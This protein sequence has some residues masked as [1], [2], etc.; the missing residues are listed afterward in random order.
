MAVIK[1][2]TFQV[3]KVFFNQMSCNL[4]NVCVWVTDSRLGQ[5]TGNIFYNQITAAFP[6][7]ALIHSPDVVSKQMLPLDPSV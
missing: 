3:Y 2:I 1:H 7:H 5:I 6:F 4:L